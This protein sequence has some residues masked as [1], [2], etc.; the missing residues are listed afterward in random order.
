MNL[1]IFFILF[2][3]IKKRY[4]INKDESLIVFNRNIKHVL[5]ENVNDEIRWYFIKKYMFGRLLM[6]IS[7]IY[8]EKT[9]GFLWLNLFTVNN[10]LFI[11]IC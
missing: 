2:H 10:L 5:N 8:D 6:F 9:D 4:M 7:G 3:K 1:L 11:C